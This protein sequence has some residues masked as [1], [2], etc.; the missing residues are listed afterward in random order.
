MLRRGLVGLWDHNQLCTEW[1]GHLS[2]SPPYLKLQSRGVA[3]GSWDPCRVK[4]GH[5]TPGMTG[6]GFG[7]LSPHLSGGQELH[8]SSHLETVAHKIFHGQWAQPQVFSYTRKWRW[9]Q[10]K[11]LPWLPCSASPKGDS[12][13][14][15]TAASLAARKLWALSASSTTGSFHLSWPWTAP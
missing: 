2:K 12:C 4:H 6:G 7:P 5:G 15:T 8:P 13:T 10:E 11:P 1:P 9:A 14:P 3:D